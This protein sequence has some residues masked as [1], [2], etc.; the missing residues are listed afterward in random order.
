MTND[1]PP[2]AHV[3]AS[4]TQRLNERRRQST[5][6]PIRLF[7]WR[8]LLLQVMSCFSLCSTNSAAD[9]PI[10]VRDIATASAAS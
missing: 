3:R 4:V 2:I 6:L 9:F 1:R 8:E 5:H 7:A 10:S